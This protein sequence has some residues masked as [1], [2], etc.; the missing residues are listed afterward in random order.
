MVVHTHSHG[1]HVAGDAELRAMSDPAIPVTLIP[2]TVEANGTFYRIAHWPE[3]PGSVDLGDRVLDAIAIPG[4]DAAAVALYDRQTGIL[5]TGDNV[6]PGR[7]Y[8]E[9]LTAYGKSNQR[10]IRFTQGRIVSHMLGNHIEQQ[11]PPYRDYPVGTMYQPGEHEL[12]LPRSVLLEIQQG[13]TP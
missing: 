1:D 2:S 5:F 12:A 9:D 8:I 13:S 3:D 4:H 6:Y 10:L 11:R 7:L